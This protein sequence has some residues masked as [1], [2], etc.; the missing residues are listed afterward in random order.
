VKEG[1]IMR[2]TAG[3]CY[4]I[5]GTALRRVSEV[6]A[7]PGAADSWRDRQADLCAEASTIIHVHH[8]L[9]D[10]EVGLW[11]AMQRELD[12]IGRILNGLERG[13]MTPS[14]SRP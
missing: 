6:S 9:S 14:P 4:E 11:G 8:R 5:T 2:L 1:D 3:G 7:G 13:A 10:E 12:Q